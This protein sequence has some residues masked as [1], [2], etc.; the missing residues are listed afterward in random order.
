M[1]IVLGSHGCKQGYFTETRIRSQ[2]DFG[3]R[4]AE[5]CVELAPGVFFT[6][7]LSS[8]FARTCSKQP[9]FFF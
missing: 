1:R 8:L 3:V 5:M 7:Y 4:D 9:T 6:C 2:E